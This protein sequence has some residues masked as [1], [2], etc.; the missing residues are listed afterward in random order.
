MPFF[1]SLFNKPPQPIP[2]SQDAISQNIE[3][4]ERLERKIK[5]IM[6]VFIF[7]VMNH[8]KIKN[9]LKNSYLLLV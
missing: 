7:I 5:H 2:S 3:T 9:V 1:S 4:S 8:L 6:M